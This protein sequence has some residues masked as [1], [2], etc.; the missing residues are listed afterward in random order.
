M[1]HRN[2][3]LRFV[4]NA[5]QHSI[6]PYPCCIEGRDDQRRLILWLKISKQRLESSHHSSVDHEQQ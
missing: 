5:D 6:G 1:I 2:I 3:Q 4:F